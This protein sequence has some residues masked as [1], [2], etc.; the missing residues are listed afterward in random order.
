MRL[1]VRA[2]ANMCEL[3][4]TRRQLTEALQTCVDQETEMLSQI[5]EA[6]EKDLNLKNRRLYDLERRDNQYFAKKRD[7][8]K[9]Y[10]AIAELWRHWRGSYLFARLERG[11]TVDLILLE[12]LVKLMFARSEVDIRH[13]R[14]I[15]IFTRLKPIDSSGSNSRVWVALC[16]FDNEFTRQTFCCPTCGNEKWERVL[17]PY[18]L[19]S[20]VTGHG[21]HVQQADWI[22]YEEKT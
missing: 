19:V 15:G 7:Q 14:K 3:S 10:E 18:H 8:L 9:S 22:V 16:R 5:K 4:W 2:M 12:K 21:H 1:S 6:A 13:L 11:E 20:V 17:T